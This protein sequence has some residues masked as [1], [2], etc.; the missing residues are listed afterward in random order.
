MNVYYILIILILF[1]FVNS[2]LKVTEGNNI[3]HT[4]CIKQGGSLL[5]NIIKLARLI[6]R[7][8]I[9]KEDIDD[10]WNTITKFAKKNKLKLFRNL[11]KHDKLIKRFNNN[12]KRTAKKIFKN[13]NDDL[14][15]LVLKL[16]TISY[17]CL[18]SSITH[19]RYKIY[20]F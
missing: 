18:L 10:S 8:T 2:Y 19:L 7:K 14:K 12:D 20:I 9:T 15:Y 1:Y 5:D 6:D 16:S 11:T 13:I 17:P 3:I 4:G